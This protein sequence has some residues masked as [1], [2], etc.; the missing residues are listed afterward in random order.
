[1][2]QNPA[3]SQI[4]KQVFLR[5]YLEGEPK[6]LVDGIAVTAD[7]YEETKKIIHLKYGDRSR[8]IQVHL[9]FLEHLQPVRSATP[10]SLNR[11]YV[12]CNRR[13]QAFRALCESI[14]GNGRILATKILRAFSEDICRRWLI[15][16]KR[17]NIS[18]SDMTRLMEHLK[19][20]VEGAL[21]TKKIRG[22]SFGTEPFSQ[23][24]GPSTSTR[25]PGNRKRLPQRDTPN[26]FE[27]F[28]KEQAIGLG[29]V[30]K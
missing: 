3:V 17:E 2:D 22:D 1:V 9:D 4:N 25:N 19:D 18:E 27:Y 14:E 6:R 26:H 7:T 10:E 12:E 21:T 30:S 24:Q 29:V 8:I 16:T 20:E 13:I 5:G 23:R 28:V 11:M 15:R